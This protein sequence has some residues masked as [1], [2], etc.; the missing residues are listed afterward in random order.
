M[1]FTKR[2][3]N[4]TLI[5]VLFYLCLNKRENFINDKTDI[6]NIIEQQYKID[7]ESIKNLSNL[8]NQLTKNGKSVV[9]GGLE[10]KGNLK[11]EGTVGIRKDPNPKVGLMAIMVLV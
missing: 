5:S 9:P 11:V 6:K 10:I 3:N 8:A 4:F 7:V 1:N 2:Y